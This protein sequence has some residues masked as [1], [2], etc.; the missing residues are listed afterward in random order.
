MP[1]ELFDED[2]AAK[3]DAMFAGL[4]PL[5]DGLHLLSRAALADLP[6]Q[7]RVLCVGAGTG[8]EVFALAHGFPGWRFTAV[9]P[10]APML[11]R[12]RRR[13]EAEGF[14][15][16]I[17]VHEGTLDTLPPGEPFDAATCFLVS[18]FLTDLD[19]RRGLLREIASRLRPGGRLL[20]S[21]LVGD[22]AS[23]EHA[24]RLAAWRRMFQVGGVPEA[25]GETM[26]A[27]L[28]THVA[29]LP[30]AELEGLLTSAGFELPVRFY[31]CLLVHAWYARR[32]T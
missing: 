23:A 17:V 22:R 5:A 13:A 14:T 28:D 20:I 4:R 11:A 10:A 1:E 32:R 21:D 3:R 6:E 29:L 16:R 25:E 24:S 30:E 19:A 12:L 31:Q 26:L 15:A 2:H 7:A 18:H 8:P 9:D 27:A